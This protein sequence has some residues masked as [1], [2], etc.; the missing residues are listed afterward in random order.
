MRS[1]IHTPHS[2]TVRLSKNPLQT[3][4]KLRL[5][6]NNNTLLISILSHKIY[7]RIRQKTNSYISN[8]HGYGH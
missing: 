4:N 1:K 2:K 8:Y 5:I 7:T 3:V 6:I